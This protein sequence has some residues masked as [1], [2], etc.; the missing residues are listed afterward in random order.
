M[1][2]WFW[3]FPD[4]SVFTSDINN[5]VTSQKQDK[6]TYSALSYGQNT[7]FNLILMLRYLMYMLWFSFFFGSNF[8]F[9]S[10]KIMYLIHCRI[11]KTKQKLNLHL[12]ISYIY[13][14]TKDLFLKT[15]THRT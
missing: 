13:I 14:N 1:K 6:M 4:I 9:I 3:R 11:P 8:I 7:K 12:Y 15:H 2:G 5:S 10:L